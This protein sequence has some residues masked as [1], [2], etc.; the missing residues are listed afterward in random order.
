[1]RIEYQLTA[2]EFDEVVR[3][4]DRG[5]RRVMIYLVA[6]AVVFNAVVFLPTGSR[7]QS[8]GLL[9]EYAPWVLVFLVIWLIVFSNMRR[10]AERNRRASLGLAKAVEFLADRVYVVD[11]V[12]RAEYLWPAFQQ[13]I[14]TQGTF[15]FMIDGAPVI[16]LPKRALGSAEGLGAFKSMLLAAMPARVRLA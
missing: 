8:T 16:I 10:G 4:Q 9:R 13:V 2:D 6:A 15:A 1:M 14:E 3:R 11:S 7:S 12:S 5:T